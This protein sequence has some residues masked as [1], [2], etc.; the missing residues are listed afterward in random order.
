MQAKQF[1]RCCPTIKKPTAR[2]GF[3]NGMAENLDGVRILR[4]RSGVSLFIRQKICLMNLFLV[5]IVIW[6]F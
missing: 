4:P 6:G 1:A 3:L 5:I 2:V